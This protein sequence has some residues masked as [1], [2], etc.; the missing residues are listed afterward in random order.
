MNNTAKVGVSLY[1]A[2]PTKYIIFT[3]C[4][5]ILIRVLHNVAISLS[6]CNNFRDN[7]SKAVELGGKAYD[8]YKDIQQP[9]N[10]RRR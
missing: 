10:I 1:Y 3:I 6:G 9:Q 8:A 4:A 5:M 7:A 2:S